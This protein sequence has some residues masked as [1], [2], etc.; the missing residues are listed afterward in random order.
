MIDN[1]SR[2]RF[3]QT[4]STLAIGMALLVGSTAAQAQAVTPLPTDTPQ[5]SAE[6][7][8]EVTPGGQVR[9]DASAAGPTSPAGSE[10]DIVVTGFRAR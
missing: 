8:T 4:A 7:V 6:E 3:S 10:S 1:I 5:Q 9:E 2:A